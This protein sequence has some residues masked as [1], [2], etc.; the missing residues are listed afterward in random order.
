[1]NYYRILLNFLFLAL[2]TSCCTWYISRRVV[3]NYTGVDPEIQP[4]VNDWMHLA[5]ERGIKFNNS[6]SIGFDSINRKETIGICNYGVG[7]REI[8]I[9]EL[10]WSQANIIS[11]KTLVF[12]ELVHCYC[13]RN[14]DYGDGV[15]YQRDSNN[16][17]GFFID[18]N[19]PISIMYPIIVSNACFI[20][21]YDSYVEEMFS[22]CEPF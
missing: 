2:F 21:H 12:H 14:H 22:R 17:D 13:N 10:Y 11:K 6:V 4:Y 19:C 5:D 8:D 16:L 1:M 7:F 18:D 3:P 20:I 15:E 9:D